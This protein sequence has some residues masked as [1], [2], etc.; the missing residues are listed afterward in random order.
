M[1]QARP[2]RRPAIVKGL[3]QGVEYEAGVGLNRSIC[4]KGADGG[5][6][7]VPKPLTP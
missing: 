5:H 6:P 4:L 7:T 2:M 3:L 1:N